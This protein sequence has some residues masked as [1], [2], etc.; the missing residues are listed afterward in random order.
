M[1]YNDIKLN[2]FESY[3]NGEIDSIEKDILLE[4]LD[5][6]Y[7]EKTEY[8]HTRQMNY[9]KQMIDS[10]KKKIQSCD[11]RTEKNKWMLKL[12]EAEY[13]IKMLKKEASSKESGKKSG[14]GMH[15][16]M[17]VA[18]NSADL[19]DIEFEESRYDELK[20][21]IFEAY[22]NNDSDEFD[23][24]TES[25][26]GNPLKKFKE[27]IKEIKDQKPKEYAGPSELKEFVDKHYN[28]I[29]K[30]SD[31]LEKEPEDLR[32]NDLK[33]LAMFAGSFVGGAA[34][35]ITGLATLTPT[36]Y[37]IG[38]ILYVLSFVEAIIYAIIQSCRS[39]TDIKVSDDLVKIRSA[40]KKVNTDKLDDK[41]KNK[42]SDMIAAIDDAETEISARMKV[43]K[44]SVEDM[45][46]DVY[47]RAY[48]GEIT[49]SDKDYLLSS[50]YKMY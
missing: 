19:D 11:D 44:E 23:L 24:Y 42:I 41:S 12:K 18:F 7:S 16:K 43:T 5:S 29:M 45:L 1:T 28:N 34:I 2:I 20:S 10:Y 4:R 50:I 40:L 3:E 36:A 8:D 38:F 22:L 37:I 48:I 47:E 39:N 27:K 30:A 6:E 35:M 33:F 31:L 21:Q 14:V 15:G 25:F 49:E 17:H 9:W 26:L 32:N 13:H 46:L